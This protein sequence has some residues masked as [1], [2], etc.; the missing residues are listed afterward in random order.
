MSHLRDEPKPPFH[1]LSRE[2]AAR[3]YPD[4]VKPGPVVSRCGDGAG[5]GH[6]YRLVCKGW[7]AG[8]DL[9]ST[10]HEP[11]AV[12]L[13][14]GVLMV[15]VILKHDPDEFPFGWLILAALVGQIGWFL[16]EIRF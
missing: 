1:G 5:T 4:S 8:Q 7:K 15:A 9:D 14:G 6:D 11:I 12:L 13:I 3:L 16:P 10:G 2:D